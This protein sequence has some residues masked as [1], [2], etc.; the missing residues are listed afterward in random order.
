MKVGIGGI[1]GISGLAGKVA[2]GKRLRLAIIAAGALA[3]VILL[4]YII[5]SNEY[6]RNN[7]GMFVQWKIGGD[8]SSQETGG[9]AVV[10]DDAR[11][12]AE[13]PAGAPA[14]ID[15]EQ[16]EEPPSGVE[17]VVET[18]S[19]PPAAVAIQEEPATTAL[20][21]E[22]DD[23]NFAILWS[24]P[25]GF[26]GYKAT[27][28]GQIHSIIDQSTAYRGLVTYKVF[29]MAATADE[30]RFVAAF[31]GPRII[32]AG[33]ALEDCIAIEGTVRGS[34]S[35]QNPLGRTIMVPIIDTSSVREVD[36]I[37]SALPAQKSVDAQITQSLNGVTLTATRLQFAGDHVRIKVIAE[38]AGAGDN[39]FIE[40][41]AAAQDG[42]SY[43]SMTH[44][45]E[46]AN[47]RL[48]S[49]IVAEAP[50]IGYLFFEPVDQN[51]PVEFTIA[52]KEVKVSE[53]ISSD[54]IF[55]F[56]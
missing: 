20:P 13:T 47:Y 10:Q 51:Q 11:Q 32:E 4:P 41:L 33:P 16:D 49:K 5:E 52:V 17:Q 53:T 29:N 36:C 48:A 22:F 28:S 14:T 27:L 34:T 25:D 37:D 24:D 56:G 21:S 46:Y 3:A 18:D 8:G 23:G 40:K 38:N 2:T 19:E 6:L 12:T 45:P 43:E 39:V 30:S 15:G 55:T 42:V 1:A 54:F 26:A 50:S 35:E 31:Q 44:L 9:S 7:Y